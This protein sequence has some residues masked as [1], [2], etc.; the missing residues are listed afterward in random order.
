MLDSGKAD[1]A[2]IAAFPELA[3]LRRKEVADEGP[4]MVRSANAE[5]EVWSTSLRFSSITDVLAARPGAR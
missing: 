3:A 2:P 5:V 1:Y 4:G